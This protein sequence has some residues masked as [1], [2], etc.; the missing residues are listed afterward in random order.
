MAPD[1]ETRVSLP[2]VA[3]RLRSAVARASPTPQT[4]AVT[5][6]VSPF[7][8]VGDA[9]ADAVN[10]AL[11]IVAIVLIVQEFRRRASGGLLFLLAAMLG[12]AC[13]YAVGAL[14]HALWRPLGIDY[15]THS[16]YALSLITSMLAWRRR[17]ASIL[18]AVGLG[19]LVLIVAM[20]YHHVIEVTIASVAAVSVT[21][22]WHVLVHRI[23]A[24]TAG[25]ENG[26]A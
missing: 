19:Y 13:V 7:Y 15:S 23:P 8:V 17:W 4:V 25:S 18:A 16:A 11:T 9:I 24:R 20:G 26:P 1:D 22:P 2:D 12:L 21:L 14:D 3:P 6:P 10:P 5:Q